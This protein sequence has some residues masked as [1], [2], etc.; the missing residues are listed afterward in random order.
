M[1]NVKGFGLG[2]NGK[3]KG[4]SAPFG[5]ATPRAWVYAGLMNYAGM[6]MGHWYMMSWGCLCH[7][8]QGYRELDND[9][10]NDDT[11]CWP[12]NY[13]TT[14]RKDGLVDDVVKLE[15]DLVHS[16]KVDVRNVIANNDHRG[17]TYK[18]FLACNP[19]EY[20]GKGGAIVYTR[21]VEE[22]EMCSQFK[23]ISAV[24]CKMKTL[25]TLINK[26]NPEKKGNR[27]EPTKD[28]NRR[29][30]NK[31][32]RTGNAF[33]TT[34]NPVRREK[35]RIE[36]SDLWFS[37]KIE[38]ASGQ[39]VEIDKEWIGLSD[40]KAEIIC[41]KKVVRIPLLDG[42]HMR[43]IEFRIGF[44][45]LGAMLVANSLYRL[46]PS[47]L[48]ELSGQAKEPKQR[49]HSDTSLLL[50]GSTNIV[51][52]NYVD[53]VQFLGHVNLYGDG[54]HVDPSK[55]E[56]VKSWEAPR[57][58]S[59]VCSFLGLGKLCDAPVLALLDGPKDFVVYYDALGIGLGCVLMQRG[60]VIA[61]TS[62]QLK[63]HERNYTTYNLELG[64]V[65]FALKIWRHYLYGTKSVIYT[66]HKSIQ[67]IF[68][69]KELNMRQCHWI[70]LFSDY[71][72]EICYHPSKANVVADVLSRKER[73]KPKR[74][75]SMNITLQSSIKDRIMAAQKEAF[76]LKGDVRTLIMDETH[77]SKYSV[78]PGAD[79]M[80]YDLR[81]MYWWPRMKKDIAV[82][83][84]RH[85]TCLK[86]K[87]EYQRPFG[88]LQQPEIPEWK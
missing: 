63:I 19:I 34:T 87:A 61:Y 30:D 7:E 14:R 37:Y 72:C 40:H 78:H 38:I 82:Y 73:V 50:L 39:L 12:G 31:R 6:H 43:E 75:R 54:I 42:K 62:R 48:E 88:L 77:K 13:R 11:K 86:V 26:K 5:V 20:N 51:V 22:I 60:K 25:R 27:G 29:D 36:A 74:V 46:A 56:A 69:Q 76:P 32:T 9:A 85:L 67:H 79:K 55:I 58:P 59:K 84:S 68:S 3:E 8:S 71:D 1:D 28:R 24:F 2:S 49:F 57:N 52:K 70:E 16:G 65:V 83:V 23:D 41:H 64:A 21:W 80:Y 47:E 44:S 66:N 35:T 18:E 10:K 4:I 45:Y 33:A 81:D 17:C 53:E 15:V